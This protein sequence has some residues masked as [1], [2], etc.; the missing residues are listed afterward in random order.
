MGLEMVGRYA[1]RSRWV[2]VPV[3]VLLGVL[4][5]HQ[6]VALA[7]ECPGASQE[8][9]VR[10]LTEAIV[11][12]SVGCEP[13]DANGDEAYTAADLTGLL[14]VTEPTPTRTRS[15]RPQTPTRT[16]TPT[17]SPTPEPTDTPGGPPSPTRTATPR[18]SS[19]TPTPTGPTP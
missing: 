6:Q 13:L 9:R 17:R 16:L 4:G 14:L 11:D 10:R 12:S 3:V 7:G 5:A 18:P 1:H 8:E 2:A 19:P 15:Q